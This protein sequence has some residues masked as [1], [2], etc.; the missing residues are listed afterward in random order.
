VPT[1]DQELIVLASQTSTGTLPPVIRVAIKRGKLIGITTLAI[2]VLGLAVALLLP[3]R[4]TATTVIL[5]PQQGGSAGAAMMAQLSSLSAMTGVG[6]SALGIKN[7]NDLQVS[8]LKSRTVEDAMVAR[9]HLQSL[10]HVKRISSARKR[11]EKKTFI[12]SG[13]KD[14]LLR[15]SVTDQ[16]PQRAA[17]MANGW[18]EEY[19]R[20]SATLAVNEASGRRLFFERQVA[21]A[22]ENLARAEEE[23]KQTEQRTGVIE[24]DGQ[25]HAMIAAAAIIR[26]QVAAKQV[27][28]Q[29][30]R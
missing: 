11:W 8:L 6:A 7:P 10:Y 9:F 27:E 3:S 2:V 12:D 25:T 30:M 24:M 22:R 16:D 1:E 15:L 14:G 23:M 18:V 28:I 20:L 4:Y 13:L 5:P 19:R 21:D 29:A 17:E 26:A